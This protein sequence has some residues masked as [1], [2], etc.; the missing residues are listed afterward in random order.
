MKDEIKEI[1]KQIENNMKQ[2]IEVNYTDIL[3]LIAEIKSL[4]AENQR[5]E[6]LVANLQL[7]LSDKTK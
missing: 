2:G 3:E 6:M 4:D 7:Q 5:Y 1:I